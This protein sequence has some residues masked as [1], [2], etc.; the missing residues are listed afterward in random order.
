MDTRVTVGQ[1]MQAARA[2]W[3]L[4][5]PLVAVATGAPRRVAAPEIVIFHGAPLRE[6]VRIAAGAENQAILDS[7]SGPVSAG[8]RAVPL[9]SRPAIAIALFWGAGWRSVADNPAALRQ[10]SVADANQT[11]RFYPRYHGAVPLILLGGIVR[12][13]SDSGLAILRRHGVPVELR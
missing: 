12:P 5:I 9:V 4:A 13:V 7:A 6:P 10:L 11:G 2:L 3:V 1:R 8:G